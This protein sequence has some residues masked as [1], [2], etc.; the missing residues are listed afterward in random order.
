MTSL[1]KLKSI[2]LYSGGWNGKKFQD[3]KGRTQSYG[4]ET[5]SDEILQ[6]I[7]E[8]KTW[9]QIGTLKLRR[10]GGKVSL[11]KAEDVEK[12]CQSDSESRR[13]ISC[14]ASTEDYGLAKEASAFDGETLKC[15]PETRL[16][17]SFLFFFSSY[18]H[19][20]RFWKL[21]H[22]SFCGGSPPEWKNMFLAKITKTYKPSQPDWTREALKTCL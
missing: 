20:G 7:P 4:R 8:S 22:R 16:K 6:W 19:F 9:E 14:V 21:H 3:R 5:V 12:Y 18:H 1:K 10:S 13:G 17:M 15:V 11:V 2:F